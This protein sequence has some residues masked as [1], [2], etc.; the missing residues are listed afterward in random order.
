MGLTLVTAPVLEPLSL[1]EAKLHCKVELSVTDDDAL[2]SAL[3]L[4]VRQAAESELRRALL[5]Q[6]WRWTADGF[7]A[8]S[9]AVL[10]LPR[11]PLQSVSSVK[12]LDAAGVLQTLAASA[13]VVDT[14]TQPGRLQLAV[15]QTWPT[16]QAVLNAT[17]IDFVAGWTSAANV[18]AAIRVGMKLWIGTLYRNRESVSP[19]VM[20]E[21]PDG[22]R[23]LWAPHRMLE[24]R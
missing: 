13:Y 8:S 7:P 1:D 12:Y 2:I 11:P 9:D 4:A 18:P 14:I 23:R 22:V 24:F 21:I 16:T 20:S 17:Q 10:H 19:A 5:T 15:D 6:T 3:M